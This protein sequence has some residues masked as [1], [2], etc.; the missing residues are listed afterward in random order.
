MADPFLGEIKMFCGNFPIRF[1]SYC[2]GQT[3]AISQF[4]AL[5][6]L[7]GTKFGGDGINT[8]KVPDLRGRTPIGQGRPIGEATTF[9]V[10]QAG[11]AERVQLTSQHIPN[12][13]HSLHAAN[14]AATTNEPQG[15][16]LGSAACY[17]YDTNLTNMNAGTV[18]PA[19]D[20]H[21][22]I[23]PSMGVAFLISLQGTYPSRN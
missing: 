18:A 17:G 4:D 2:Q 3:L 5:Y 12:H 13:G 8:F 1:Y 6:S 14:V 23:Q 22:N 11:G 21:F 15:K 19:S 9:H 16:S 7:L 20:G 10:G